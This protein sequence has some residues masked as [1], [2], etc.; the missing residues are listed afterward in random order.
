M[1]LD[2]SATTAPAAGVRSGGPVP[3]QL[4]VLT[5][6]A[7]GLLAGGSYLGDVGLLVA[8]AIIQLLLVFGWVLG[9]GLPG[10]IG[11]IGLGVL[12]SGGADAA[13]M[14]WHDSGYSPVLGVLGVAIPLMFIHQ[15]TRGV[16]RTR[17][18]ESLA[19]I[20]VLLISVVALAG[21]IVLRHQGNG[22][23]VTPAIVA[24]IAAGLVASHFTDAVLPVPRFDPSVD[25]GLP[26]VAAGIVVGGA[27]GLLALR[28]IID[29]A[30]G[31]GAFVGAA[32]AAVACLLSI[33]AT[34]SGAHSS[35]AGAGGSAA[36]RL[37][38]MA[39]VLMTIALTTPAAYVL[40]HALAG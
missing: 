6:L 15:L 18:V 40:T 3:L 29:Y 8:I 5:A 21:L 27:V 22:D 32:V 19:D 39:A 17:V 14:H 30:G 38:P 34:F 1:T 16:V 13:T 12:A 35:L 25:R 23:V 11:A 10:R 37:R 31:R 33:G 2:S 36:A 20:T 24:A 4:A 7:G 28:R 26:A 9:T